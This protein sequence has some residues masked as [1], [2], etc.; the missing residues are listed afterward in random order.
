MFTV[1]LLV[2]CFVWVGVF[3]CC[4]GFSELVV[5]FGF[6][7]ELF[8]LCLCFGCCFGVCVLVGFVIGCGWLLVFFSLS[9]VITGCFGVVV[10][11]VVGLFFAWC[12]R[13]V[14]LC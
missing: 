5:R 2:C 6:L 11:T 13:L 4:V 1:W 3:Y 12:L 8:W 10:L 14:V 7:F 9:H